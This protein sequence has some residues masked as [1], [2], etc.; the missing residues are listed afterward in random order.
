MSVAVSLPFRLSPWVI[1]TPGVA[2]FILVLGIN[3]LSDGLRA[4][5]GA[6]LRR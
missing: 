1:M 3:L 4:L 2:L 5:L 6:D